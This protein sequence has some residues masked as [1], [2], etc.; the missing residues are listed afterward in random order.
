MVRLLEQFL[1]LLSG[2]Q[3]DAVF[4]QNVGQQ[5]KEHGGG[6]FGI[7]FLHQLLQGGYQLLE[8]RRADRGDLADAEVH[9]RRR[10]GLVILVENLLGGAGRKVA[11]R[12]EHR[13]RVGGDVDVGDFG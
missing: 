13:L 4:L 8:P 2:A 3:H 10:E 7:L 12:L 6:V 1:G 11:A 9:V 5:E